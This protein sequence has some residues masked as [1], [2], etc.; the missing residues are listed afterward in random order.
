MGGDYSLLRHAEAL[1]IQ[2]NPRALRDLLA[3]VEGKYQLEG[4][5]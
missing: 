2:N 4:R 1:E 3:Y 5:W